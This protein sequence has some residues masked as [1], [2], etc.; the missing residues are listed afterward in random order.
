MTKAKAAPTPEF[1]I[2]RLYVK[3]IS[4]EAPNTPEI[5]QQ[6][7]QPEVDLDLHI[8]NRKLTGDIHEVQLKITIHAKLGDKT[9][10][11]VELNQAGIFTVK[12]F[13]EEKTSAMLGSF[14]PSILYPYARTAISDLT[15]KGG[16]PPL[17]LAPVNFDAIYQQKLD[18]A[19]NNK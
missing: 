16:F 15:V 4:F 7:W 8:E 3:D 11:M 9:A 10:F 5:F 19:K 2:Q 18:E 6:E 14:C 1:D 17:Y 12:N 13:D